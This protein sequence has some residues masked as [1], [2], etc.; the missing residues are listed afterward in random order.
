M[1]PVTL[2][3][4][5][6]KAGKKKP[7]LWVEDVL[8]LADVGHLKLTRCNSRILGS[9]DGSGHFVLSISRGCEEK[10]G[11]ILIIALFLTYFPDLVLLSNLHNI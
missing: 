2:L 4:P 8:H 9:L 6:Q 7:F 3:S 5:F 11:N 1:V 10:V